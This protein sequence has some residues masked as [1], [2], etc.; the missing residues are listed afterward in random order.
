MPEIETKYGYWWQCPDCGNR[1]PLLP[2][3]QAPTDED[4]EIIQD[5]FGLYPFEVEGGTVEIWQA[6]VTCQNCRASFDARYPVDD[7]EEV[8]EGDEWKNHD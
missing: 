7:D 6:K 4:F 5:K 8:C 3:E 1:E 2:H